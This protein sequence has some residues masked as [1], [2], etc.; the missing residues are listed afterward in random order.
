MADGLSDISEDLLDLVSGL[1][2]SDSDLVEERRSAGVLGVV[3]SVASKL[4]SESCIGPGKVR[5]GG[6]VLVLG[7]H[8]VDELFPLGLGVGFEETVLD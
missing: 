6:G 2:V 1:N 8:Q 3:D 4:S 5:G 7:R